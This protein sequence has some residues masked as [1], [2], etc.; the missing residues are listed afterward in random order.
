MSVLV[1]G[2][3]V[4]TQREDTCVGV[5]I[6]TRGTAAP[7]WIR[8][9]ALP[10]WHDARDGGRRLVLLRRGWLG[11]PHVEIAVV[12][13]A[14]PGPEWADL[15]ANRAPVVPVGRVLDPAT[16]LDEARVRGR[17][18]NVAP[19]YLPLR[20]EGEVTAV[21]QSQLT[22]PDRPLDPLRSVVCASLSPAAADAVVRVAADD[23]ARAGELVD[24]LTCVADAHALGAGFGT[25][26]LRSHAEALLS[27]LPARTDLRASFAERY[28]AQRDQIVRRVEAGLQQQ[29]AGRWR[30]AI[31]YS[32]GL[33]DEHVRRGELTDAMLDEVGT[34]AD[35]PSGAEAPAHPDTEF[36]RTVYGS[37]VTEG[38]GAWFAGY[39]FLV[40]SVYAQLPLLDIAPV[41]R[42]YGCY[43]V[44][45][46]VDDVL[47]ETWTDRLTGAAAREGGVAS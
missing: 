14:G 1:G 21:R 19:P 13:E 44:A 36:H 6:H 26:S 10:I 27:W 38:A 35:G 22:R 42:A 45:E 5:R 2:Q 3:P 18:E 16:Y 4:R 29:T 33:V 17:L 28:A 15:T 32:R 23:A 39:R 30:T 46:A 9:A 43:A 40:N 20:A 47:G 7:A 11:G 12:G 34:R 41:Q 31:A 25:F 37:G 24:V 8:D